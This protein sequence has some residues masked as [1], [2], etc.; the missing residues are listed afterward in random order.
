MKLKIMKIRTMTFCIGVILTLITAFIIPRTSK[1]GE[2]E[3]ISVK[4]AF[5]KMESGNAIVV[6]SYDDNACKN[7]LFKGAL[8][9]SEFESRVP[10]LSKN[11]EILFYC[12]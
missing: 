6:C 12:N 2:I 7:I 4:E 5:D 1:A 10:S 11:Q 8:L 3:R 9:R